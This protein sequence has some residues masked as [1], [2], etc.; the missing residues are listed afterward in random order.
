[1][2]RTVERMTSPKHPHLGAASTSQIDNNSQNLSFQPTL[3]LN[4]SSMSVCP[5]SASLVANSIGE[6]VVTSVA[7]IDVELCAS[8]SFT[9]EDKSLW[10]NS[11]AFLNDFYQ[12]G[13]FCDVEIHVG[14]LR[15]SCHRIVLACFSQYFR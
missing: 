10:T 7:E 5:S 4:T 15:V 2:S 9:Y 1:M 8:S 14:S 6:Q 3:S 12:S 13:K 11:F